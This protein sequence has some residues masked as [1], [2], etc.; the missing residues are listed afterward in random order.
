M[1]TELLASSVNRVIQVLML[2]LDYYSPTSFFKGTGDVFNTYGSGIQLSTTDGLLLSGSLIKSLA[3]VLPDKI[4]SQS[5]RCSR[6]SE[7]R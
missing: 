5:G 7:F 1:Y 6:T 2:F 3:I 4:F